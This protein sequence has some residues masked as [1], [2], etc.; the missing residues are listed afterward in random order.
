MWSSSKGLNI[1]QTPSAGAELGSVV[2]DFLDFSIYV[3]ADTHVIQSWY[4][5]RFLKLRK[6]AFANP[7]SYFHRYASLNDAEALE[8][9][10][11]LWKTINEPNLLEN[12]L[13]TRQRADLIIRKG[14]SHA[15]EEISLRRL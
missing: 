5:E 10:R 7:R 6:T 14:A 15:V 2:S 8:K 13:G 9:A 4:E 1:L 11:T 12:I 3:D